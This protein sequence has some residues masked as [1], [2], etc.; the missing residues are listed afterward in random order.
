M[1]FI[2]WLSSQSKEDGQSL[3]TLFKLKMFVLRIQ[4]VVS[5]KGFDAKENVI[6]A[7]SAKERFK[8]SLRRI[9]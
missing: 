7:K 9:K 2:Q 5:E 6:K 3:G 1:C 8:G 4:S